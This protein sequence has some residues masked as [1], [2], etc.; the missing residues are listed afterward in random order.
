MCAL[1]IGAGGLPLR[2]SAVAVVCVCACL[3]GAGHGLVQQPEGLTMHALPAG[4]YTSRLGPSGTRPGLS[5]RS[6]T[7]G[8]C[9]CVCVSLSAP[10]P[11]PTPQAIECRW[12]EEVEQ[13]L[14]VSQSGRQA[15]CV[16]ARSPATHPP[17][18]RVLYTAGTARAPQH[19][20]H[21]MWWRCGGIGGA[22]RCQCRRCTGAGGNG[23]VACCC[24]AWLPKE[25]KALSSRRWAVA[26]C[27]S[28]PRA[29]CGLA[30]RRQAVG[31]ARWHP[32]LT[33]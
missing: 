20:H 6:G 33:F 3:R 16:L 10:Q 23:H 13:K 29:V 24:R 28:Q 31:T 7:C 12:P 27:C 2:T 17:T 14:Q 21:G 5:D 26:C 30:G 4:Q 11:H 8:T 15:G 9:V 25:L 19:A 22:W 1:G 18:Q 32:P